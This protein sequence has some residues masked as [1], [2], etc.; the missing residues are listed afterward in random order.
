MAFVHTPAEKGK[1]KGKD[2]LVL[3]VQ[4][5]NGRWGGEYSY[6]VTDGLFGIRTLCS[7][8]SPGL[9]QIDVQQGDADEREGSLKG[10]F[11][12]G[13][14]SYLSLKQKSAGRESSPPLSLAHPHAYLTILAFFRA[15]SL[16]TRYLTPASPNPQVPASICTLLFSPL[17]GHISTSYLSRLSPSLALGTR[18]EFNVYSYESDWTVGGEWKVGTVSKEEGSEEEKGV[19]KARCSTTGVSLPPTTFLPQASLKMI[20][21]LSIRT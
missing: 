1:S 17:I 5:S 20:L 10:R 18:Y 21:S 9:E 4:H 12:V 2:G 19:L 16:A 3:Q 13:M 6:S 14:E 7:L 11:S 15:V 8:A